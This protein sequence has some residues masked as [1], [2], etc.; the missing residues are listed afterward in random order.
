MFH[1]LAISCRFSCS[2]IPTREGWFWLSNLRLFVDM[3]IVIKVFYEY[4][5]RF[6]NP[7]HRWTTNLL[8]AGQN[9]MFVL[10]QSFARIKPRASNQFLNLLINFF[11]LQL[12]SNY[13]SLCY[14][15]TQRFPKKFL[16][17]VISEALEYLTASCLSRKEWCVL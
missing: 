2:Y 3:V 17:R 16:I 10:R 14:S 7:I 1:R 11:I 13:E 4:F 9:S 12:K 15:Q 6:L 5:F 8:A